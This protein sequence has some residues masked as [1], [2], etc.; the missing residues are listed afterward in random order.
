MSAPI[1]NQQHAA[2]VHPPLKLGKQARRRQNLKDRKARGEPVNWKKIRG[3]R[4]SRAKAKKSQQQDDHEAA[5]NGAPDHSSDPSPDV[6]ATEPVDDLVNLPRSDHDGVN[7]T[8]SST[9]DDPSDHQGRYRHKLSDATAHI[10]QEDMALPTAASMNKQ[11][12]YAHNMHDMLEPDE[13][14]PR[15]PSHDGHHLPDGDTSADPDY[16]HDPSSAVDEANPEYADEYGEFPMTTQEPEETN[17]GDASGPYSKDYLRGSSSTSEQS[18]TDDDDAFGQYSDWSGIDHS[19]EPAQSYPITPKAVHKSAYADTSRAWLESDSE[20][21]YVFPVTLTPI[22]RGFVRP[23]RPTKATR[24]IDKVSTVIKIESSDDEVIFIKEEPV[25]TDS[26][27]AGPPRPTPASTNVLDMPR[28]KSTIHPSKPGNASGSFQRSFNR[29]G[30]YQSRISATGGLLTPHGTNKTV[31]GRN[32]GKKNNYAGMRRTVVGGS[33]TVA[34]KKVTESQLVSPS[35]YERHMINRATAD[36]VTWGMSIECV[37]EH[38]TR[39]HTIAMAKTITYQYLE[40]ARVA[41]Q[42][43]KDRILLPW[44]GDDD[45]ELQARLPV[46]E[47]FFL[48]IGCMPAFTTTESMALMYQASSMSLPCTLKAIET[49]VV[50]GACNRF[51]DDKGLRYIHLFMLG[52][53]LWD[54][55]EALNPKTELSHLCGNPWCLN[56]WHY[57]W[58]SHERNVSRISCMQLMLRALNGGPPHQC[59]HIIPCS[60]PIM[61]IPSGE[62]EPYGPRYRIQ[63]FNDVYPLFSEHYNNRHR[64]TMQKCPVSN[65]K[66][67]LINN[68]AFVLHMT[69]NHEHLRVPV[70]KEI[71]YWCNGCGLFL[72]KA[73]TIQVC[74]VRFAMRSTSLTRS[75]THMKCVE[76][77]SRCPKRGSFKYAS[78]LVKETGL[79]GVGDQKKK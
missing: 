44:S 61:K 60:P 64:Q 68:E 1:S 7:P 53:G 5:S 74:L 78:L 49:G 55:K 50:C 43:D 13:Y 4:R 79:I 47:K 23:A 58:E 9:S 2:A 35:Q 16:S 40:F 19:G 36:G 71:M 32:N 28:R 26:P 8:A 17:H 22:N 39:A 65:C 72:R 46:I 27:P 41:L 21:E 37:A 56:P 29:S 76:S 18:E 31:A 66:K 63:V 52:V 34:G 3:G 62:R 15:L 38:F 33:K 12:H 77:G 73:K 14:S 30:T 11:L 70:P 59:E 25:K 51:H 45:E 48:D 42:T 67:V 75:Q 57:V 69:N 24:P 10:W 54:E 20:D 6:S